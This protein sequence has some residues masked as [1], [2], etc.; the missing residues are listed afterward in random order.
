MTNAQ[1]LRYAAAMAK[2]LLYEDIGTVF[3]QVVSGAPADPEWNAMLDRMVANEYPLI[4][5]LVSA[6]GGSP[7]AAQ[8]QRLAD[9]IGKRPQRGAI[10]TESAVVRGAITAIRW[11]NPS[12]D[13]RAFSPKAF[14]EAAAFLDVPNSER[15]ARRGAL[16]RMRRQ[17]G[18]GPLA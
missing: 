4:R 16:D 7:N 3:V 1:T 10:L 6:D 18:L 5:V 8:R 2:S 13:T 9:R 12:I 17:L 14:D 11:F 15:A